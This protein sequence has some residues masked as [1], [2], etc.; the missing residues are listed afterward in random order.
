MGG[1]GNAVPLLGQTQRLAH[2]GQA[3]FAALVHPVQHRMQATFRIAQVTEHAQQL[4]RVAHGGHIGQQHGRDP[5][6]PVQH[7]QGQRIQ[8]AA[9]VQQ[10]EFIVRG[11]QLQDGVHMQGLHLHGVHGILGRCQHMQARRDLDRAGREK[12]GI[13]P[14][15]VAR[16]V[17]QRRRRPVFMQIGQRVAKLQIQ[18]HDQHRVP[19][20][21]H[22]TQIGRQKSGAAAALAGQKSHDLALGAP[23][24]AVLQFG[25]D[26]PH[27]IQQRLRRRGR[28]QHLAHARPHGLQ[29]ELGRLL[30]AQKHHRRAWMVAGHVFHRRQVCRVTAHAVD[31][32]QIR[33]LLFGNGGH[34]R[35]AALEG[36]DLM[37]LQRVGHLLEVGGAGGNDGYF[38]GADPRF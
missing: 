33:L 27:G 38:H 23:D 16:H 20:R 25:P 13:Q 32:H 9:H 1:V 3:D 21:Q 14:M 18:I 19:A 4:L 29:Q 6:G 31:H 28:I 37:F 22:P 36:H 5:L 26:P 8:H 12:G 17:G 2:F 24:G 30:G 7:A 11:G 10:D 15:D 35:L 34:A